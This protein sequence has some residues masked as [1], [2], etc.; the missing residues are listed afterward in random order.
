MD[1]YSLS[2][3]FVWP[4]Y[5]NDAF[6]LCSG[7]E[8]EEDESSSPLVFGFRKGFLIQSLNDPPHYYKRKLMAGK[9]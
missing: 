3:D 2:H 4:L 8:N 9:T 1:T 6:M 7:R 5:Q